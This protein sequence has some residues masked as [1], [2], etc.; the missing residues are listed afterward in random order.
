[1]IPIAG[2]AVLPG[3][4]RTAVVEPLPLLLATIP[5]WAWL[6]FAVVLLVVA[7]ATGVWYVVRSAGQRCEVARLVAGF[8]CAALV[9]DS[10]G[11]IVHCNRAACQHMVPGITEVRNMHFQEAFP[12]HIAS[13]VGAVNTEIAADNTHEPAADG[14]VLELAP[15]K[16][17]KVRGLALSERRGTAHARLVLIEDTTASVELLRALDWAALAQ[18]L[19]HEIKNPLH[20]VLLTLQRLQ[21][22]YHES[23]VRES[24]NLDRY[25]NS[26]IEEIERLRDIAN[27]FLRF[28][29]L[30]P[31]RVAVMEARAL[32]EAVERQVRQWLPQ[33][34]QLVVECEEALPSVRVDLE[35]MQRLFF[36]LF[37]NAVRTM[38][39]RGRIFLRAS[40]THW[41]NLGEPAH[42][43][44][45]TL[46]VADTGCGIPDELLG[47]VFEPYVSGREGGTGLGLTIC[48]QIAKEHGGRL[49]IQSKV[50]VGTT[51]RLELPV[52]GS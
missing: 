20:T 26:A 46:E 13:E 48:R 34:V 28:T 5:V 43:E 52:Y 37:D 40:R 22:A 42:K 45:V 39:S 4:L 12:A 25:V 29:T 6:G 30:K 24:K 1:M 44:S 9:V 47:R 50:G 2:L 21:M 7:A 17:G 33:T 49:S 3:G 10:A 41:L 14:H 19:A 31:P 15:G 11:R 27:G 8:P 38:K 32:L 18:H 16:V 36:N 35:G 51:V 23:H